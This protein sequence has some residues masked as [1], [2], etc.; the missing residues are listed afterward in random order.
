MSPLALSLVSASALAIACAMLSVIVV[1]RK[2]TFAG[3]GI[4]HSGFGGAGV[5]WLLALLVPA[6]DRPWVPYAAVVVFCLMTALLIARLT[7]SGRVSADAAV[8]V[9]L[10]ASLALGFLAQH[11]YYARRHTMPYGFEVLLFGQS[12]NISA[13]FA[14]AAVAACAAVVL[15]VAA[16]GKEIAAFAFDPLTAETSGVRVGL[17]HDLLMV[18]LAVV[19]M[20]GA[21]LAGSVLVVALLVLPG[22]TALML[23]RRLGRVVALSVAAALLGTTAG[24]VV[25]M[26]WPIIPTGPAIVLSLFAVFGLA[27]LASRAVRLRPAR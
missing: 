12:G 27:L 19:I 24:V 15:I 5:A 1:L 9:F 11:V 6:L 23:S 13:P 7:R 17:I 26:T 3:E 8:G 2:W 21:R 10:V 22:A 25:G 18:L 14:S 4:G 16:L 20:I